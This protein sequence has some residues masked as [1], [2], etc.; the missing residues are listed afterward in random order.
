[1]CLS[2][3]ARLWLRQPVDDD[4]SSRVEIPLDPE[5]NRTYGGNGTPKTISAEEVRVRLNA[6]MAQ[7][8]EG[9]QSWV[10]GANVCPDVTTV[11]QLKGDTLGTLRSSASTWTIAMRDCAWEFMSVDFGRRDSVAKR[12]AAF[13]VCV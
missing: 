4:I 3:T 11:P 9:S 7:N 10:I 1:M 5:E 2:G 13:A 12:P 8:S 6:M